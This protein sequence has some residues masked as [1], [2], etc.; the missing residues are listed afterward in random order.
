MANKDDS[1]TSVSCLSA[2]ASGDGREVFSLD[3]D[4]QIKSVASD[5]CITLADG[6]TYDV[7]AAKH[8]SS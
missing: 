1:V 3:D 7:D 2:L 8:S 6:D 4:G 5:K